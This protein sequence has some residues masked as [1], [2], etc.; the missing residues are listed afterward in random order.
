MRD[1]FIEVLKKWQKETKGDDAVIYAEVSEKFWG[2]HNME[3]F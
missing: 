1:E 2:K 3:G